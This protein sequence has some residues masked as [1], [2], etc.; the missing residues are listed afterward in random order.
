MIKFA[1]IAMVA[2]AFLIPHA[3]NATAPSGTLTGTVDVYKGVSATCALSLDLNTAG[4]A[5]ISLT[6]GV[7]CDALQFVYPDANGYNT[8]YDSVNSVFTVEDVYVKTYTAGDCAGDIS[9]D[10]VGGVLYISAVL[11][12]VAGAPCLIDGSAS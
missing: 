5:K 1:K 2:S 8:S 11:P 3:A 7:V 10:W 9:G 12:A 4:K 6:G